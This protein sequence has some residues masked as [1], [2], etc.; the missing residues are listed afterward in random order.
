MATARQVITDIEMKISKI[1]VL[2]DFSDNAEVAVHYAAK[3]ARAYGA[4]LILAHAYLPPGYAYAAPDV[5][6]VFQ[7]FADL[8][9]SLEDRLLS[10]TETPPLHDLKCSVVLREGAPR[11]LLADL[12]DVDLVVVGTAGATGIEK[13][14]LG[15]TAEAIFRSS[16]CPVLTVGPRC[17]R[18]L[19]STNRRGTILFA[20]DFSGVSAKAARYASSFAR[21]NATG[22][23]FLHVV[24]DKD[25]QFSFER[26]MAS[27]EPLEKLLHLIP[28]NIEV[29]QSP[30]CTIG[31][32]SPDAAILEEAKKNDAELIV[33]GARGIGSLT[34]LATHFI[35]GT[36]Y[37]VAANAECP[38]LTIRG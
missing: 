12:K 19:T 5:A 9:R 22:L 30:R 15:S 32:G 4:S 36:A 17:H 2:T 29:L 1:A 6:L 31:F 28:D 37:K 16:T 25:V 24:D 34:S 26:S 14:A 23:I 8:R 18:D 10:Q 21:K 7:A 33:L 38:V 27:A 11:E 13:T 3:I 20:T 35:G